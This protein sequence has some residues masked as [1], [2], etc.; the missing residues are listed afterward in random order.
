MKAAPSTP[1]QLAL[2]H[3]LLQVLNRYATA[4]DTRNLA[5]LDQVF[6]ADCT[7]TY[8]GSYVCQGAAEIRRMIDVHMG[9]CGP[10]QH[11][12]GNLVVQPLA[13]EHASPAPG[14]VWRSHTAVRA[15]HRGAG[16]LK[17][18]RYDAL[19]EYVDDWVAT[20]SGWR[21]AYR[22]MVMALEMGDRRVLCAEVPQ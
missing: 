14:A 6:T 7:A 8:G 1:E 20:P 11:L 3:A 22:R 10:T 18:L 2:E 13:P 16:S 17:A 9:G 19:G 4:V 21:I 5:L 15:G 12:L